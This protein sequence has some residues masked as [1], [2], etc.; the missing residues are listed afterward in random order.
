M[1][2]AAVQGRDDDQGHATKSEP[3]DPTPTPEELFEEAELLARLPRKQRVVAR[4]ACHM[5]SRLVPLREIGKTAYVQAIDVA[6]ACARAA[7]EL[8]AGN[9]TLDDATDVFFLTRSKS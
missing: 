6:R 4:A 2:S 8:L 3:V 7:G 9:G 5:A 1:L